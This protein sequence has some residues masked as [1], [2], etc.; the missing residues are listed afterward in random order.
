[1]VIKKSR[2]QLQ[3]RTGRSGLEQAVPSVRVFPK[4]TL[5][6]WLEIEGDDAASFEG[7]PFEELKEGVTVKISHGNLAVRIDCKNVEDKRSR[8]PG[9]G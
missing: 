1:M 2:G 6:K 7:K 9:K 8:K 5:Q 4:R 3:Q